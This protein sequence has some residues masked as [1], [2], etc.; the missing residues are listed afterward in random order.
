ML[1]ALNMSSQKRKEKQKQKLLQ[2]ASQNHLSIKT[3]FERN[4][5]ST[6]FHTDTRSAD[7][8]NNLQVSLETIQPEKASNYDHPDNVLNENNRKHIKNSKYSN[9]SF[10]RIPQ[11]NQPKYRDFP[12]SLFGKS[13]RSF[14]S[15]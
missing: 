11:K 15:K 7:L 3:I 4:E 5:P 2:K 13:S 12:K 8:Q 6:S 14:S 9:V 10:N 1:V